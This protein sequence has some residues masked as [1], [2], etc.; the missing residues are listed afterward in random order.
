MRS[1]SWWLAPIALAIPGVAHAGVVINEVV[2]DPAGADSAVLGEWVELFNDGGAAVDVSGWTIEVATTSFSVRATLP[3]GTSVPAGGYLILG[4]SGVAFADVTTGELAMGNAGASGDAVRLRDSAAVVVDTVVYGPN[5]DDGFLQDDGVVATDLVSA[6]RDGRSLARVPNGSDTDV[7]GVDFE[8]HSAPTPGSRN[9][10]AVPTCDAASAARGL[11]INE[12]LADPD[13]AD[14]GQEWVELYNGSGGPVDLSGWALQAGTSTYGV[15]AVVPAD[16]V[17]ASGGFLLVGGDAVPGRDLE[18]SGSVPNASSNADA[19]RVVDCTGAPADTLVY[20]GLN[21]DAWLDDTGAVAVSIAA[22]A[23][24]GRSMARAVDGVDTDQA[25]EDFVVATEPTPGRP[26][27]G[28]PDCELGEVV[29]N[30][31]L[32][33]PDGTDAGLEWVELYNVGDAEITLAGWVL[34]ASTSG[35]GGGAV[36]PDVRIAPGG[37]VLLGQA[38][39]PGADA[40]LPVTLGNA[41][42]NADGVQLRDCDG[43]V[44]DTVVYG[45]P[46]DDAFVDDSGEVAVSLA[47][48]PSSGTSLARIQDG[49]DNDDSAIDF[50]AEPAP[51]P[52]A[53]NPEREPVIC[54]PAGAV[55]VVLNEAMV[56]PDGDDQDLEWLELFNPTNADISVAGWGLAS[57]SNADDVGTVDVRFPGGATVPAGG[58]LVL[59]GPLIAE[60]EVVVGLSLGNG[61]GGDALVL[62]DCDDTRVDGVVYGPDNED[63]VTDDREQV[64][65]PYLTTITSGASLARVADGVDSDA[66]IDWFSDVTPSPGRTNFQEGGD[67]PGPGGCGCG[68]DS[69][70]PEPGEPT[71]CGADTPPPGMMWVGL[72]GLGLL[73]RR[74]WV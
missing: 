17:L 38:D 53:A 20:G 65:D 66:A 41:S 29:I 74:R 46:N 26:N 25:R 32:P 67:G 62:W 15:V 6:A 56:N 1:G 8:V 57:A 2:H 35:F 69:D 21:D 16:R 34:D 4:E 22:K 42:S 9:D 11:V 70:T 45:A 68:P 64:V 31:L 23:P 55:S 73:V 51:T 61:T 24:S 43:E 18:L 3:G 5:N 28:L 37:Y 19:I 10:S 50:V 30:E 72:L 39:V 27:P 48:K 33:D 40:P 14:A 49:Y 12:V 59:G 7:S 60:V 47:P 13:G 44:V 52:G 36:L 54:V 71:G 58:F 63:G